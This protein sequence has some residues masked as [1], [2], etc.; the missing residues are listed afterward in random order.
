[1]DRAG[2]SGSLGSFFDPWGNQYYV[3]I[4]SNY[5]SL[6]DTGIVYSDFSSEDAKPRTGVGAFSLGKDGVVG[7]AKAGR[8]S[9]RVGQNAS[10]DVISWQ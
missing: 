3:L 6:L 7:D 1:L 2:G 8:G 4:D 9:Y 10:D 5:D